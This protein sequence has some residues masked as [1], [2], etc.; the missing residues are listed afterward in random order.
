[1][2]PL[3]QKIGHNRSRRTQ[4]LA[5]GIVVGKFGKGLVRISGQQFAI[6]VAPTRSGRGV[7]MPNLLE[8]QESIVVLD[9]EQENFHL[10]SGL[11]SSR[12]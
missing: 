1:M 5:R 11:Q 9:I 4:R 6:L 3:R 12:G 2:L 10:T 7:A 8:Y